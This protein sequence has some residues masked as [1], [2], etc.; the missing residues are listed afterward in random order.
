MIKKIQKA[1]TSLLKACTLKRNETKRNETKRNET[2]RTYVALLCAKG[3][4]TLSH[5]SFSIPLVK[6]VMI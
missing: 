1:L 4:T 5:T 2:K 6:E 3:G